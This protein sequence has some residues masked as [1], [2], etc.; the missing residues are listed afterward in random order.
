MYCYEACSK[1]SNAAIEGLLKFENIATSK[2]ACSK[3][4]MLY[5][6][7]CRKQGILK[8]DVENR[9]YPMS[10]TQNRKRSVVKSGGA[11][12]EP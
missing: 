8:R 12:I 6:P 2:P 9:P 4:S 11:P 1:R 5:S 3:Y 7:G 10:M